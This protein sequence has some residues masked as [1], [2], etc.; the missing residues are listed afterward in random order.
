MKR[1]FEGHYLPL[2]SAVVGAMLTAASSQA[3]TMNVAPFHTAAI[4]VSETAAGGDSFISTDFPGGE[5]PSLGMDGTTG[6]KFLMFDGEANDGDAS[7]SGLIVFFPKPITAES[8]RFGFANDGPERDPS[9]FTLEGSNSV[10]P[11]TYGFNEILGG[12]PAGLASDAGEWTAIVGSPGKTGLVE[13][14]D[15]LFQAAFDAR[16]TYS[17]EAPFMRDADTFTNT[18]AYSAY[19]IIFPDLRIAGNGIMQVGEIEIYAAEAIPEPASLLLCLI[20][21]SVL[22]ASRRRS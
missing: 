17:D 18:T 20:S 11:A 2:F 9:T 6:T 7:A 3:A 16:F 21:G 8:L 19:R 15:D 12:A 5:N 4:A 10:T 14:D 22:A 13:R 1:H